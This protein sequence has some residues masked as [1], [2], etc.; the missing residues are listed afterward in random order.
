LLQL[1]ENGGE[2]N[3]RR[4]PNHGSVVHVEHCSQASNCGRTYLEIAASV[5]AKGYTEA[6]HKKLPN[7]FETLTF[8]IYQGSLPLSRWE[9]GRG[10]GLTAPQTPTPTLPQRGRE[11]KEIRPKFFGDFLVPRP[12]P[13]VISWTATY[14]KH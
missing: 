7:E 4:L 8:P 1:I 11:N 5:A 6:L 3:R 12:L 10:E 2:I 9:R 14:E 13:F